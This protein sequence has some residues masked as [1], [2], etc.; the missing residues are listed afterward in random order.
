MQN[1]ILISILQ[2]VQTDLAELAT[3]VR[4]TCRTPGALEHPATFDLLTTP[5]ALQSRALA[6][7]EQIKV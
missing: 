3:L 1:R 2:V 4:N 7:V 5:T 6:L